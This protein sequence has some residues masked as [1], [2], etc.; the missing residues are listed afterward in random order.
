M[1]GEQAMGG[2]AAAGNGKVTI[3]H[4][5]HVHEVPAGMTIGQLRKEYGAL[6]RIP[7][8]AKGYSGTQQMSDDT[9]PQSGMTIEY[10]K[11]SGEKGRE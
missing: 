6:F 3:K 8:D 7:E 10:V 2:A 11:K 1:P 4:G 5:V 9:V